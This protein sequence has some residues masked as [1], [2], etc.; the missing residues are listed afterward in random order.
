MKLNF[1]NKRILFRKRIYILSIFIVLLFFLVRSPKVEEVK[2]EILVLDRI[3]M[4]RIL[5]DMKEPMVDPMTNKLDYVKMG[6]KLRLY[7]QVWKA[8]KQKAI[9]PKDR[10]G[11]EQLVLLQKLETILFP[12]LHV[13]Y[14]SSFDMMDTYHGTGI[15]I[16]AG[17]E[18]AKM[19]IATIDMIRS[20]HHSVLPV[21]IVYAG[22][23]DLSPEWRRK[24]LE[25]P[26][27]KTIDITTIFDNE[28][29][30]FDGWDMKPF[31]ILASSFQN[32][33]LMDSDVV[34]LQNPDLLFT[35]QTFLNYNTI[36]FRDRS[37]F[38]CDKATDKWFRDIMP[39]PPSEYSQS[40]RMFNGKSAHEQ[41]SG[42]V[43]VNKK[44]VFV[45]L[46]ATCSFNVHALRDHTYERVFGDKETFWLGFE[47]VQELYR[48][49]PHL[50]GTIG[51]SEVKNGNS[52]ICSR[53][54]LH[55]D[56]RGHPLWINGGIRE[57]KYDNKSP[58]AVMKE[59]AVEPGRW[60]LT[61]G[62]LACL[63]SYKRP[64]PIS[65]D[66]AKIIDSSGKILGLQ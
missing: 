35:S 62:N 64:T 21:E 19:T 46:L 45:G 22:D 4:D 42:V 56:E 6:N 61:S 37:L 55:L 43:L 44:E 8:V 48:F 5:K 14:M 50:P 9:H 54:I 30:G 53:Q 13:K 16:C 39:K 59:W 29:I 25:I 60:E 38:T 23:K 27:T 49:F 41:E 11:S 51:I 20:I 7:K 47:A 24:I 17:N 15:V 1:M 28:Y 52:R 58:L 3:E 26:N 12:W 65:T 10:V 57:S 63:I 34:F 2:E 32:V 36:F 31:A 18:Q 33:L 66:L 40:F